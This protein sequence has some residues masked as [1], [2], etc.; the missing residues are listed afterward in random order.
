MTSKHTPG[1]WILRP[2]RLC[3]GLDIVVE[4][5]GIVV[6]MART[7]SDRYITPSECESNACLIAAAPDLLAALEAAV[8]CGMVPVSSASEGGANR[9]SDQVRVADAIRTAIAKARGE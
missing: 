5:S 2:A 8:E 9:Y 4:T 6:G 1:P 7:R 3:R